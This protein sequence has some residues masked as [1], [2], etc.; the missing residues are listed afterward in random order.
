MTGVPTAEHR[1]LIAMEDPSCR[2][3]EVVGTKAASLADLADA[4]FAVPDSIVLSAQA[5]TDTLPSLPEST[6]D[7]ERTA[8]LPASVEQALLRLAHAWEGR[9]LA[10]RSSAVA[11]D[12]PGASFAGQY[13]TVLGVRGPEQLAAAVRRCW[14]S[15]FSSRA[16]AY[17][18]ELNV[19]A[20]PRMAVLVQEQIPADAAGV[21]FSADPVTGDRGVAVVNAVRGLGDRLVSGE[22][23]PEEWRVRAGRPERAASASEAVL[24]EGQAAAVA[25]LVRRVAAHAGTPQDV[26]WAWAGDRLWLLQ[27]RPVTGL[28]APDVPPVPVPAEPP[29]GYWERDVSHWPQ[30]G[31][32]LQTSLVYPIVDRCSP[33]FLE[34]FGMLAERIQFRDIGGWHYLR[35]VPFGGVERTPPP[36]PVLRVLARLDPRLRRRVRHAIEAQRADKSGVFVE[37][38]YERWMP[39]LSDRIELLRSTHPGDLSD[40]A[41]QRHL[42]DVVELKTSGLRV[43]MLVIG[44][45][46]IGIY[47]LVKVCRGLLGWDDARSLEMLRGLSRRSTEPSRGLAELA[48][49]IAHRPAV[50]EMLTTITPET[51]G[52]IAA[53]DP[54]VHAA[55]EDYRRRFGISILS[56]DPIDPTL[57]ERPELLLRLVANQIATG[58]DPHRTDHENE[59]A[60]TAVVDEARA[61]LQ[62]HPAED[63]ARFEQALHQAQQAYP[64]REDNIFFTLFS[65][66]GL[67][68]RAALEVGRRMTER[69]Q[70]ETPADAFF[71]TFDE[72]RDAFA[73][74]ADTRLTVSRRRGE[75]AW[76]LAH[77]GPSFYGTPP[78][79][80]P[81]LDFLPAEARLAMEA[82]TW[83]LE[84]NDVGRPEQNSPTRLRGLPASAGSWTGR[85][86][87]VHGEHEFD[88]LGAGDVL[89]CPITSPSWSV[90]FPSVGALVTDS[91]GILNHPA[92]IAREYRVP[93]V[94][95]TGNAT[96]LLHDGQLVTVDGSAGTVR[97]EEV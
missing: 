19:D 75:R 50:R 59:Q 45:Q 18:R 79:P 28:P 62:Q 56:R 83:M 16:A 12:L 37:R 23:N 40:D 96:E 89:V 66:D 60:R 21:A 2:D 10:V 35:V 80:P 47:A 61:I 39:E 53:L 5:L 77:P 29:P 17:R 36:L 43:H 78:G 54:E 3:P 9:T 51:T 71:L 30:P 97:V 33:E 67:L 31:S 74:G 84:V 52:R 46:T 63:R 11:E 81:S 15:A 13:E 93:A 48:G 27:A 34:E 64:I 26:E 88:K 4:G 41:L 6:W 44:A 92:I 69:G 85:V 58:F 72:L 76:V 32:P 49:L 90:L 91:G 65:P 20:E 86:R 8:V 70:A 25:R 24:D 42:Q 7:D 57:D 55:F 82:L 38:W 73:R 22:A 95:A 87:V 14:H 1:Y 94:V 68:R